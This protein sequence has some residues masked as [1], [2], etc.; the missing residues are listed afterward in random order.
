MVRRTEGDVLS[1][2]LRCGIG[3]SCFF[4]WKF[5]FGENQWSK[6]IMEDIQFKKK[7][8]GTESCIFRT[9]TIHG[10]DVACFM[11]DAPVNF[12]SQ[13][14]ITFLCERKII[15]FTSHKPFRLVGENI[16]V[17]FSAYPYDRSS[18]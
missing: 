5:N 8:S 6:V 11:N 12:L 9:D 2:P 4:V 17:I 18:A 16:I 3:V 14:I 10:N 1:Q 15:F 7:R 13:M